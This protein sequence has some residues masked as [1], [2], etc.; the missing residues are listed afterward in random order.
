MKVML[1]H[2]TWILTTSLAAL[3]CC[4]ADPK[5]GDCNMTQ[6]I[7]GGFKCQRKMVSD[8]KH[9]AN[10]NCSVEYQ[11]Q[12]SCLVNHLKT[13][14]T[15]LFAGFVPAVTSLIKLL[16][17]HCGD[18]KVDPALIDQ[19][20]LNQIQCK[21]S[22]F[23][24]AVE[25]WND[26]RIRLNR[27]NTDPKLCSDYAVAKECVTREAKTGCAI[28]QYINRD[29]FNPFC[30]YNAD[31]PLN[32]SEPSVFIGSCTTQT[33]ALSAYSCQREMITNLAKANSPTCR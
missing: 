16:L 1:L 23:T 26:F 2:R 7:A 20:L 25:C 17:Y 24:K 18:L 10:A 6:F 33:F 12:I 28:G 27:D 21:G 5:I 15:G 8:L 9:K 3:H 22:V 29:L 30:T 32:S 14:L 19:F 4:V 13:Y 31:P 11:Y